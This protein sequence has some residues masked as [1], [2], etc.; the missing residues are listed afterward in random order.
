MIFLCLKKISRTLGMFTINISSPNTE[1]LR[2]F[3][4]QKELDNLFTRF[5]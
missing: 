4:E 5:K 1:G 2:N 3:H